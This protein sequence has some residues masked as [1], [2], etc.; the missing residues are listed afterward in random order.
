MTLIRVRHE[1]ELSAD[2]PRLV[3]ALEGG[4]L[5]RTFAGPLSP[6]ADGGE[7]APERASGD[8]AEQ[9]LDTRCGPWVGSAHLVPRVQWRRTR[10]TLLEHSV[11]ALA[12]ISRSGHTQVSLHPRDDVTVASVEVSFAVPVA[13]ALVARAII[14]RWV[15]RA[16]DNA[17]DNFE[18]LWATGADRIALREPLRHAHAP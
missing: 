18:L 4:W 11:R 16:A 17:R 2:V 14:D 15:T 5:F 7:A 6:A 9:E 12:P 3:Q 8:R 13:V 10:G 1:I